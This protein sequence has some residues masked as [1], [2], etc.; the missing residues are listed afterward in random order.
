MHIF[1]NPVTYN[2]FCYVEEDE[3]IVTSLR[4]AASENVKLS[5]IS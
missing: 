1:A 5:L 4:D 3:D 2:G